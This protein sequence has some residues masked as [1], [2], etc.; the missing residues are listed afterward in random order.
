MRR[1][2]FTTIRTEG[3]LFPPDFLQR[4]T[5]SSTI[6]GLTSEAYHLAGKEKLNEASSRAWNHLLG[7]WTVFYATN[8]PDGDPGTT[9]T[10]EKWLLPLFA[11]LGYGRLQQAKA[12]EVNGRSY[13]ISHSWQHVPIH[14]VGRNIDLDH[15]TAGVAGAARASPHSLVQELLNRREESQWGFVSNGLKF[16]LLRDNRSLTRQ[17]Y[18]EF[19][20]LA[21]MEGQ[22]FSDFVLLWLLCHQ[23]R[24]EAVPSEPGWLEKWATEAREQGT[25]ALDELRNG[26]ERAIEALGRGFLKH[27]ANRPLL[28][29][30]RVGTLDRQDYYRQLLRVVYRLIFLFV[31][32]ARELLLIAEPG[33]PA[34]GRYT[35][36]YSIARLRTLA[37]IRRGTPH[38]DLWDLLLVIIRG[39]SSNQG[40][41]ELGLPALG[42]LLWSNAASPDLDS[43]QLANGDLLE[44]IRALAFR[45]ERNIRRNVDWRNLGPEELGSVYESLLELHPDVN[46]EAASFSLQ[47]AAG[48]ERKTTGSYYTPSGLVDCLLDSALDPVLE[49]AARTPAPERA[50]L[51]LKVCDPACGSGHFLIAAA[52]RIARRLA[53]VRTGDV[54]ASPDAVRHALRDVI[55]HCV[56]GV[57]MN[58]MAVELCKV[59]LWLEALD[60]GKPLSFLDQ[61][62]QCGN[63]LLGSTAALLRGGI[64]DT[65]FEPIEGD[66]PEYCRDV[67]RWNRDE[68]KALGTLFDA[69]PW[70]RVGDLANRMAA[71]EQIDD[72]TLQG[73][74]Q[75]E[76]RYAEIVHS[77]SY[78]CGRLWADSWC[79][80]FVWV[81]KKDVPPLTE[82]TF[83][84][85]EHNPMA[86]AEPLRKKI[87]R[88]ANQYR[89]FHWHLAFPE[90]FNVPPADQPLPEGPGW[91]G[92]FDVVIG[93][94][95]W[96]AEELVEKEFF[97]VSAPDIAVVRTKAKRSALIAR[98]ETDS[99][100]LFKAW[101][102]EV[103]NFDA[104]VHF[105]RHSGLFPL[106]SSGKIN[107]YRLFA[108]LA[109]T[110]VGS[111]GRSSQVL[112]SGI[113]SAQ[114]GQEL[115]RSWI[116]DRRVVEV[117]E[118]IN[119]KLI[120]PDVVA[121]ERFC[122]L[123]LLG[124]DAAGVSATYAF[125]LETI[126][127]ARDRSRSFTALPEELALVN[128]SDH[129]VP[130]VSSQSDYC[131]ILRIHRSAQ[132]LRI[133]ESKVNP[134]A[135]HYAQGHLNSASASGLF[136]DNTLEELQSR[137]ATLDRRNWFHVDD[138]Y[139]IPLYE[140]KYIA[141]LNHRFSSFAGVPQ[142]RRFGV[143]AE[144]VNVAN[145]QL[146]DPNFEIQPRYWLRSSDAN[147]RFAS[148]DTHY[149]W[150]FGFR[151][152]CRA[153][154]DARTVQACILPRL[155][156]LDGVP[157]LV[158]EGDRE[159]AAQTAILFNSLWGSFVFDYTAREKIH[160]AHLTK[161]IAYQLPI[162]SHTAFDRQ[163]FGCTY[164]DFVR[165]RSLELTVVSNSLIPFARDAG[166][167]GPS[168]RWNDERRFLLR[169]EL[170]AAYFHLY[171]ASTRNGEW[172]PAERESAQ[173][174]TLLKATFPTPRAAVVHIMDSFPVLRRREEEL[175][176][177]Y[178]S[179]RVVLDIYDRMRRAI[180]AGEPYKTVLDSPPADSSCCHPKMKLGILAYGSLI[181]DPGEELKRKIAM[182]I[183]AKTPFGVE[184]GRYSGKA[185]GGAPT[186]VPHPQGTPVAA[187]ILVMDDDATV[188]QATDILWRRETG[189]V[190]FGDTYVAG[191]SP[192]SV[193]VARYLD[194]PCVEAVL[195]TDFTQEGRIE[196]PTAAGLAENAIRSVARAP[197]GK[198]GISYLADNIEHGI[199][200]PLTD[201]YR[202]EIL[203][204]TG[205]SS[206]T[207]ALIQ[208]RETAERA[209]GEVERE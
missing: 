141:Q 208:A 62:I 164:Q 82:K 201:S 96:E 132:A 15:R 203:R 126:Q 23:S 100:D 165:A 204:Q 124:K 168:F 183:K 70:N 123:T 7:I 154:V 91:S 73:V 84:E 120:F 200:T 155:P 148:K 64:P 61:K 47:V 41:P 158:F 174:L 196:A 52:H 79:A 118:F 125:G 176:G 189:K 43:C 137:G 58:E 133:D 60:P 75:I 104:R 76:A 2:L 114:E 142:S 175:H 12:V 103:R 198:D 169:C 25:R 156:C 122:W 145:E 136:A 187:E 153:I 5:T 131:L 87:E 89:F 160:G 147:T 161:A 206:L 31:A 107:T 162:P 32:E 130:P 92:G 26:V 185:R 149:E 59:N 121:N 50:I 170:D 106:G 67:K 205:T 3:G 93:N 138:E 10:R 94:P 186:L 86:A 109:A 45:I 166:Y 151:D 54:E 178:R 182:R 140:G 128:P 95:P 177:E 113:V 112:K 157:L 1:Q 81:K 167:N 69:E 22:A 199:C 6:P 146:D 179:K 44:A 17:A 119:T 57:D 197:D 11:E 16:R 150:L 99:P 36:F 42:S 28:E 40:L 21:M 98:L 66:D 173:D 134:W 30:L 209:H 192:N 97:A 68:R 78:A 9:T 24:V 144:A 33:S 55:G 56:Y 172:L 35:R 110:L 74:H 88:I 111:R 115:F 19:D 20:L 180:E 18:V 90:V 139:F 207:E 129:S 108:E 101:K 65:A 152:V 49:H 63:S 51:R 53:A 14:L 27:R 34:A 163:E 13:P 190:G 46:I 135:V 193:L 102:A 71:L 39:L 37:A 80:A 181:Y 72:S 85:I 143:K 202:A 29:K 127:E 105:V 77:D 184:Y 4:L 116:R 171:L 83:R 191:T 159:A 8:I 194:D 188:E 195:Y 117:R 38:G 48:H